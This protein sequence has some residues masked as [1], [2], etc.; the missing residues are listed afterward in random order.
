MSSSLSQTDLEGSNC[1]R[2]EVTASELLET[3][4]Q[5]D[6]AVAVFMRERPRLF[7]IAYRI[8]GNTADAEDVV[9]D[10]WMRWQTC[11]RSSIQAP[12]ALL[13]TT[14]TRLA[15]NVITSA[16]A[17]HETNLDS[18][19]WR[20]SEAALDPAVDA[21]HREALESAVCLLSERLSAPERAAYILREAFDYP[22]RH[23]ADIIQASETTTRQLV[24]RARKRVDAGRRKSVNSFECGRLLTVL[25]IAAHTGQFAGLEQLFIADVSAR[26]AKRVPTTGQT[27]I[28]PCRNAIGQWELPDAA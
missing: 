13:M 15:I 9:Q 8:V 7:S 5:P 16:R 27:C 1:Q 22:Y 20:Q 24:S 4:V 12:A 26:R 2:G 10:V 17:R 21:E 28:M 18:W 14:A 11:D 19:Q 6:Q 25:L 23:I 3:F